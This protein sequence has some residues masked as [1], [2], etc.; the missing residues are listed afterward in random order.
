V[1]LAGSSAWAT[2]YQQIHQGQEAPLLMA[3]EPFSVQEQYQF[4]LAM[5]PSALQ[6]SWTMQ[7]HKR[8]LATLTGYPGEIQR[9]LHQKLRPQALDLGDGAPAINLDEL[10]QD[11]DGIAVAL[12][13][14]TQRKA[15]SRNAAGGW[16]WLKLSVISLVA[17]LFVG[18]LIFNQEIN[19]L[20]VGETSSAPP[21]ETRASV[22]VEITTEAMPENATETTEPVELSI[23]FDDALLDL[24]QAAQAENSP[25]ELAVQFARVREAQV[26]AQ[27]APAVEP[28]PFDNAWVQA[29]PATHYTVQVNRLSSTEWL[30]TFLDSNNLRERTHVYQLGTAEQLQLIT[31]YGSYPSAAQARDAIQELPVNVQQLQPFVKSFASIQASLN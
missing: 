24:N 3:V 8:E 15:K 12:G 22:P 11:D 14:H 7:R 2:H 27:P 31:I 28:K 19:Q 29:Q 25:G 13:N 5:L 21:A 23:N 17:I 4:V 6:T 1:V 9:Y 26:D 10:N 18:A 20:I 16:S 30:D